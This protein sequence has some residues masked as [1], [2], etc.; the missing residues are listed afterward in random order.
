MIH[1]SS[2][3][4]YSQTDGGVVT[5]KDETDPSTPMREALLDTE[6][7]LLDE[8]DSQSVTILRLGGIYGPG[9]HA[10]LDNLRE[11]IRMFSEDPNRWINQIHR[12][13]V[14]SAILHVIQLPP[15]RHLFN[16]VDDE[17][18]QYGS[19]LKW[20]AKQLNK[21][22][23]VFDVTA[24]AARNRT[25]PKPN[26]KISNAKLRATGWAPMYPSF[27]EGFEQILKEEAERE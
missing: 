26:R 7:L 4:V 23:P 12:D 20:L 27:R 9:R 24:P 22:P 1:T 6:N 10:M 17:P 19:C 21:E 8:A 16:V 5:E 11:D 13:D 2:T 15:E 25:G 14:V 18:V 3:S